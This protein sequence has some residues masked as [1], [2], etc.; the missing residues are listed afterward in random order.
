[1]VPTALS[2]SMS[3][4]SSP[5][6]ERESPRAIT[7]RFGVAR[8]LILTIAAQ[9]W[10]IGLS[11]VTVPIVVHGV[12][13]AAYGLFALTWLIVGY[14]G[15]LDLGLTTAVVRCLSVK[16]A[17][18]DTVEVQR[19]VS[20][21]MTALIGVG[22]SGGALLLGLTQLATRLV[23]H[24]PPELQYDAFF[25]FDV[26]AGGFACNMWLT[27]FVAIILAFQRLELIALQ[28]AVFASAT[29]I[30]Q[31]LIIHQHGSVRLLVLVSF[32]VY[33]ASLMLLIGPS[34]RLLPAIRFRPGLYLGT[35]RELVEFGAFRF[36]GQIML[37]VAF[38]V[39][40]LVLA[41]LQP[42][43]VL[44]Y[45]SVPLSITQKLVLMQNAVGQTFFPAAAEL[46]GIQDVGRLHTLYLDTT[47]LAVV[48]VV[49]ITVVLAIFSWPIL[50]AW[51]G[52][53]FARQSA[54][55]LS[56]LACAYGLAALTVIPIQASDAT[57]HV[58]WTSLFTS[59]SAIVTGL[60]ALL[61]VRTQG[62]VGA[63][64][65]VTIGVG[66]LGVGFSVV[67]QH[68][69]VGVSLS[70]LLRRAY[71]RPLIAG[72]GLAVFSIAVA[73]H[74]RGFASVLAGMFGAG[75]VYAVLTLITGTWSVRDRELAQQL[76]RLHRGTRAQPT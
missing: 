16:R 8:N 36:A 24:I 25:S 27:I 54:P 70:S 6:S 10:S 14:A 51:L 28:S 39:D 49:P 32:A 34:R 62:G 58:R 42:I 23:F 44:A 46:H 43:A 21:A 4:D 59:I 22:V 71:V 3:V 74:V 1:M 65:A 67:V 12:G 37:Q 40:R 68:R 2:Q 26:V 35:F 72:G 17:R 57:G 45:Y 15:L 47:K 50:D 9:I 19:L 11:L 31:V 53:A 61:L 52:A 30:A 75:V 48:L 76:L 18:G 20:T 55:I 13:P 38:G 7:S 56:V 33:A 63:A 64:Y 29:A 41:L 73:P 60:M 66:V 5:S 69:F